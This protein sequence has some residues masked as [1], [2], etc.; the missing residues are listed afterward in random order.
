MVAFAGVYIAANAY[1]HDNNGIV[2]VGWQLKQE[3][4]KSAITDELTDGCLG[5]M[6]PFARIEPE[7]CRKPLSGV[8]RRHLLAVER[9]ELNQTMSLKVELLQQASSSS[10]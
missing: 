10:G 8:G 2:Q 9:H 5:R 4:E 6:C 7:S 1:V 3:E